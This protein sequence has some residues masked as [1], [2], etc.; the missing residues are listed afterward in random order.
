[1]CACLF[2]CL[3][4][5]LLAIIALENQLGKQNPS[6]EA[7]PSSTSPAG[8]YQRGVP[9]HAQQLFATAVRSA[10]KQVIAHLGS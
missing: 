7:T 2:L 5:L 8:G 6:S 4:R 3:N 1:V 10:L 9:V